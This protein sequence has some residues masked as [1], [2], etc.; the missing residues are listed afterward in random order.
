[1]RKL[2]ILAAV[3]ILTLLVPLFVNALSC[4]VDSDCLSGYI[5]SNNICSIQGSISITVTVPET[6]EEEEE[7]SGNGGGGGGAPLLE[8]GKVVFQGRAYPQAF[9]TLFKNGAVAATFAAEN[10]GLFEKELTGIS[11]GRYTFG[12]FAEDTEGRKSVT[13]SFTVSI[14]AGT[15]TTISGIFISPTI[16]LTP[17]QIEKGDQVRIFGQAFPES[18]IDIFVASKEI[19]E[20][21]KTDPKGKWNYKLDTSP[22]EEREHQARAKAL[23]EDGE[24]SPFSQTLSFLVV[25][26]GAMVCQGADLNFD[27]KVDIIDFSILLYFWEQT[28]PSNR[29]ADINFDGIVNIIDFSIMMYWWAP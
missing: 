8:P 11:A 28:E 3:L 14:L 9:L 21:T 6:E 16:A 19:V 13:L 26:P 7:P 2:G 23:F 25:A 4:T 12:I 1:M 10:S 29:C 24:Q 5:C 27:G 18:Q 15:T 20:E 22:L 17:T